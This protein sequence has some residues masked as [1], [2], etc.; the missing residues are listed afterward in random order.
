MSETEAHSQSRMRR[1]SSQSVERQ[2]TVVVLALL[3]SLAACSG[4]GGSANDTTAPA[5]S[6]ASVY[7][8]SGAQVWATRQ[9]YEPVPNDP[10]ASR[11]EPTLDWSAQHE[12]NPRT[13]PTQSVRLSGH[14]VSIARLQETLAGFEFRSRTVMK[15]E[16]R[17]GS[18]PDGP[19][20][21]LLPVSGG[22]HD[23]DPEL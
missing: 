15:K 12:R 19:R 4:A 9:A 8:V 22:I 17:A 20:V 1:P 7:V 5:G 2:R 6:Q 3:C 14:R 13:N 11:A 10:I 16:G 18:G 23:H 21:M